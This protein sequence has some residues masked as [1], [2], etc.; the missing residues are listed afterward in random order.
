MKSGL[1][2]WVNSR[3]WALLSP[4]LQGCQLSTVDIQCLARPHSALTLETQPVTGQKGRKK[5]GRK[6]KTKLSEIFL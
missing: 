2:F 6:P 5:G 4:V 1:L 3:P